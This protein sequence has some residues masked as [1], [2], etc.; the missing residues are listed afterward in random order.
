[1]TLRPVDNMSI[2]VFRQIQFHIGI[3]D[4]LPNNFAIHFIPKDLVVVKVNNKICSYQDISE[5]L[6]NLSLNTNQSII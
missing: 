4:F 3:I 2:Y 5:I 1:L 6:L